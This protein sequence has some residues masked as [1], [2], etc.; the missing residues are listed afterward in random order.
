M[1]RRRGIHTTVRGAPQ[2]DSHARP[3]RFAR[4]VEHEA[5]PFF[6]TCRTGKAQLFRHAPNRARSLLPRHP[7]LI[8]TDRDDPA[9]QSLELDRTSRMSSSYVVNE[10]LSEDDI[11]CTCPASDDKGSIIGGT[12]WKTRIHAILNSHM[13]FFCRRPAMIT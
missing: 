1:D 4:E 13:T 7:T 6:Q 12:Y 9:T 10:N 3:Y 8:P 2:A 11:H 5:S